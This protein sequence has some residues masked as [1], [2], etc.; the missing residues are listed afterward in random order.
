MDL[1]KWFQSRKDDGLAETAGLM[2]YRTAC[3][4]VPT[5][6]I[7]SFGADHPENGLTA[8]SSLRALLVATVAL[9][10]PR[11]DLIKDAAV[12]ALSSA[13]SAA[14]AFRTSVL[15]SP[16]EWSFTSVVSALSAIIDKSSS[17]VLALS[18]ISDS[19][20][21]YGAASSESNREFVEFDLARSDQG[22]DVLR[23]SLWPDG[24][25]LKVMDQWKRVKEIW[26]RDSKDWSFWVRW[27]EGM[28][29]LSL[30][31]DLAVQHDVALIPNEVWKTGP[32]PVAEAIA[33]IE[34]RFDLKAQVAALT[35]QLRQSTLFDAS[36]TASP[37]HRAHNQPPELV[38]VEAEVRREVSI[39]RAA[40]D[41]AETE[42]AKRE[43][44]PSILLRVG[45]V[46]IDAATRVA[47]YC[48]SLADEA[49]KAA[50]KAIGATVGATVVATGSAAV[51]GYSEQV[52]SL[53]KALLD[54][55]SKLIG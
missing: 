54:Y 40:L 2:A 22:A 12:S 19:D 7:K 48:G 31:I 25:P 35:E 26:N 47:S 5:F 27:Y 37:A 28:I 46:L 42:L 11:D 16:I 10:L 32:G 30:R 38:E 41:E 4:V 6:V 8:L 51:L 34:E 18:A 3:R 49:L 17:I 15:S 52:L 53:G 39:I 43:P 33:V 1:E 29:E 23:M 45:K 50:A 24:A 9:E 44:S 20:H 21:S 13:D 36:Q 55:A 14:R